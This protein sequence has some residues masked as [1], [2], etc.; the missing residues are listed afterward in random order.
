MVRIASIAFALMAVVLGGPQQADST[1]PGRAGLIAFVTHTYSEDVGNGIA[2]VRPDA[3]G[4][5]KLTR[6][7]RDRSP[8]WSPDGRRLAFERAGRI[9]VVNRDGTGLRRLTDRPTDARQPAWSPDGSQIAFTRE[10]KA[11]LLVVR[12]DGHDQRA[13]Y[14]G[15]LDATVDRPAWSPDGR[16]IAFGLREQGSGSIAVIA[17][18]GGTV[19]YVT[20][21]RFDGEGGDPVDSPDDYGPDWSPDGKRIAFTRVVWLCPQCDQEAIFSARPDGSDVRWVTTATEYASSA[22][23]WSPDGT[24]M[25][26][27]TSGGMSIFSAT[28]RRLRILNRL[29]TEPAWQPLPR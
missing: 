13:L 8:A 4:L 23:S 27:Q 12:A 15:N 2:V 20:D 18:N 17:R 9:Y 24:R 1:T 19:R 3:R 6:D 16:R 25:V 29:G 7:A 11:V 5:R 21:G 26:A 10:A 28:G 22:P 14:R